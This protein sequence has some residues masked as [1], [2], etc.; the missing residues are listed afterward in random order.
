MQ[1]NK[2]VRDKIPEICEASGSTAITRTLEDQEYRSELN[3][4]LQEEVT[5]YLTDENPEELADILEVLY[6]V[7][8]Q[9]G[10]TREEL[11]VMRNAKAEERGGFHER[12]F[13]IATE[14]TS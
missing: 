14:S 2:L 11:E 9:R 7:A 5:E 1:Y 4:K 8:E 13:L 3:R 12:I 10:L 6:A